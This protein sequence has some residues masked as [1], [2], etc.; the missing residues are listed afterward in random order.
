VPQKGE[1]MIRTLAA[2]LATT[3][4]LM[5]LASPATAQTRDFSIQAGSL[6]SALDTFARQSG[7]QVIYRGDE[8]R[9][10]RSPGVRG[11][12]TAEEAL[13]AILAGTGFKAHKDSSG[14]FAVAKVGNAPA[15][16]AA[17]LGEE[18]TAGAAA[19]HE[20]AADQDIVVTGTNI[21]GLSERFS[22][23]TTRT[24][25]DIDR[26]GLSSVADVITSLPQNFGGG[27]G[28]SPTLF[29][30]NG[31][32]TA[33]LRGLGNEATLTLVN[34]HRL[35]PSG[36]SGYLTDIASVPLA[37]IDRVEVLSDGASA[38]YGADAIAG[39]VNIILN[40]KF[41]GAETRLRYGDSTQGGGAEVTAAQTIGK[42]WDRG[43][44]LLSYEY[45]HQSAV[46]A[47]DRFVS[48]DATQPTDLIPE[49]VKHSVF[50]S[51]NYEIAPSW[52]LNAQ[53]FFSTRHSMAKTTLG[54]ADT[55]Y[56]DDGRPKQFGGTVGTNV[57]L[58]NGWSAD[59]AVSYS[60]SLTRDFQNVN[61][62]STGAFLTRN[63]FNSD[64]SILTIDAKVGG[65]IFNLGGGDA[66]V[67]I[68][69]QYRHEEFS[70]VA[71]DNTGAT[72]FDASN[73]RNVSA[74]YAEAYVPFVTDLN[75][76]PGIN[77]LSATAAVRYERYSQV[78]SAWSPKFGVN[79]SPFDGLSL[80]G[81]Y[82][83]SF[84]APRLD[85]VI[86]RIDYTRLAYLVDPTA[87]GGQSLALLVG[88]NSP[89]LKPERAQNVT[90]G[91][92]V[93][94]TALRG[95]KL[96]ATYFE[97][98]F[99]QRIFTP[100][101]DF[102][103][104]DPDTLTATVANSYVAPIRGVSPSEIAAFIARSTTF[105]NYAGGADPQ[106]AT[107]IID[108]RPINASA[109]RVRG[110]DYSAQYSFQVGRSKLDVFLEGTRLFRYSQQIAPSSPIISQLNFVEQPLKTK[111][112]G[113]FTFSSGNW[114]GSTF[115][116]HTGPYRQS[117]YDDTRIDPWTTF[118]LS[119]SYTT[120]RS[121]TG[122]LRGVSIILAARNLFDK[123]PP[124]ALPS[125][126]AQPYYFDYTNAD[127]LGRFISLQ[128]TKS[129]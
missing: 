115:V 77:R 105:T 10:A 21:R 98:R 58:N 27:A 129:W 8:V 76:R 99:K 19:K 79:Y 94:P 112:R 83:R 126:I 9:A 1:I 17:S 104:F 81:T 113:G 100:Y 52:S 103:T 51:A 107:V 50:A 111:L 73:D 55:S 35:A 61:S 82:G 48:R 65:P 44:F 39:V 63:L 128:I 6:R 60:K 106:D 88:G 70:G 102:L 43:N 124:R 116:N 3:T 110:L 90:L 12:H 119:V 122:P 30:E 38:I 20:D 86:N 2:A 32:R 89:S 95:L 23:V 64:A 121:T 4:C 67:A 54:P 24:R 93:E 92:D 7:R 33:N 18:T 56:F 34:G 41:D 75:R 101:S 108:E 5:A 114:S 66:R 57:D 36:Y 68:G 78:G 127:P 118:D 72:F 45:S 13:D 109:T 25:A 16:V 62:F 74:G 47:T 37:A 71:G 15:A 29:G 91:F 26:Q 40:N 59:A 49:Q 53:G 80:R 96:S 46:S 87:P 84:R 125:N 69:A 22:P 123:N 42:S 85:Q 14:A 28:G 117:M 11:A 97:I 120:P 31:R